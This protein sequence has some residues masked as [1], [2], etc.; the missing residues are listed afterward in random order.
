MDPMQKTPEDPL[1]LDLRGTGAAPLRLVGGKALNLGKLVAAGLPVPRGF[2]LTTVAYDLAA[3]PGLAA[4]AAELDAIGSGAA[5]SGQASP[6]PGELSPVAARARRLIEESQIPPEVDAAVRE[7]YGGMGG[8]VPV[9]VRSSATAEDLPFASFAGQQDSFLDVTGADAVVEAVRRCWASLW[10]ERAVAYRSANGISNRDVRLAVVVQVMVDAATAGVLFTA[11]PVT[12]TRTETVINASPGSGQAVVSGA[13]NPDQFVVETASG[14][15]TQGTPGAAEPGRPPSLGGPQLQELTALGDGVQ[16]LFGAPQD[17][18]WAIEAGGKIWVTQSRPITTLYPLPEPVP[19]DAG[20]GAEAPTRVYLCGTLF[21][22]LTRPITPMGLTVLELMRNSK[23]PWRYVNPGL[24][25]YVDL[26]AVARSKTGREYL[27]RVLPLADG[28]S[29]AVLPALLK[30]PRFGIIER[31]FRESVRKIGSQRSRPQAP[32]RTGSTEQTAILGLMAGLIPAMVR[33]AVRPAA[34]LRRAMTYGKQLESEMVLAEPA[35]S[36]LRL[37]HTE[38]LLGRTINRLMQATLPGP[39]VGYIML[40]VAR[41]LLRG[42]AQPRELEAV[43][44]GLPHN[45]TTEMDLELWQLA[46]SIGDDPVSRGEFLTKRPADLSAAYLAGRLPP[47]AQSGVRGFLARYGHRA[48]AE[49]D[50]GMPRWSEKPDHILGMI[51]NYLRV[52]DPEQAPDRQFA[53]AAEH[54]E[55]RIRSLVEQA[56]ARSPWRARALELSLR[57]VRQ[58]AGMRELPKFYIVMLLSEM[59]R[60]LLRIG[61]DMASAGTVAA[62]DDVFFLDFDEIRVGLRGADLHGIVTDRRRLYNTELR[63]RRIPRLLLSDGT[64]VEAALM[65]KSPATGAL[66]GTPASAGTATGRV[67]VVLDPVG[68]QLEPGEI[69]VAPSTDPGWTPLFMTAGALVMEMGGVISHGAVVAREY[70]IPA[71]VGVP[72]ATT[73]LHTGQTVAVDGAAG[74]IEEN[75]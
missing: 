53:R 6:G 44:R 30:D 54:A 45:I 64:D 35:S 19:E 5:A 71:V 48:V 13:V 46:V 8:N 10:S 62:A 16:R 55:D 1:V 67:R 38:Q 56:R 34:E 40:A 23:G 66:A 24:R 49:I 57:R 12:G 31:S 68:A 21:Q 39:S 61:A 69:L 15:V 28:R 73:R 70:G 63:R 58:L 75:P 2:C 50:L 4:L 29:G 60:Q 20:A 22:G 7:T 72:D 17:I 14:H 26:T 9:A 42:I 36:A 11:N 59:H 32:R 18:E 27:L 47:R 3:P 51:S 65:A 37:D 52:D 33:P 25:M 74:T 43:L 41:R